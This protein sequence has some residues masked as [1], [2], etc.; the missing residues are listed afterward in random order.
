MQHDLSRWFAT[1]M[2]H[3]GD[4]DPVLRGIHM[5]RGA[6][7]G[8]KQ[9]VTAQFTDN[10]ADYHQRYGNTA[11]FRV[12][13]D[14]ALARLDPP[15]HPH[16]IL[17]IG[18]GSGNSVFPLLDRYPDATIVATDVS[19][20]LLAILRD[21]LAS[22]PA[23]VDRVALVCVDAGDAAYR[24]GAFDLAVG[25]AILHH[26]KDPT[27]VLQSCR[28][29]LRPGGV[30]IFFEPFE[31]GHAVLRLAYAGII[32]EAQRQNDDGPGLRMLRRLHD[33]Y[34][35]RRRE[36]DDPC[37]L[38][39]DDK[40]VFTRAF[41][42]AEARRGNWAEC[43]VHPIH[44]S[45]APL[46]EETRVN[47]R[48]GMDLGP[49]SLPRWA[50]ERLSEYEQAFSPAA[51]AELVFEGA[52]VLRARPGATFVHPPRAAWWFD[53]AA[54][55]QGFFVQH[56]PQA[57]L[58]V[59]CVYDTRGN[60]VWHRAGPAPVGTDGSLEAAMHLLALP[61]SSHDIGAAGTTFARVAGHA[62]AEGGGTTSFAL[63]FD[64]PLAA[65]DPRARAFDSQAVAPNAPGFA[66]EPAAF[67]S[68]LSASASAHP[69]HAWV[70][71]NGA[72]TRLTLQH[73]DS[74]GWSGARDAS[75]G[76]AWVEDR[77]DPSCAALVE[78]LG[79][80]VF[81]ALLSATEWIVTVG[82]RRRPDLYAGEWL[83]FRGG[84]VPGG[85][86]QAPSAPQVLGEARLWWTDTDRM[87]L[88]SP[89]GEHRVLRRLAI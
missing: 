41:F 5:P 14:D 19:P 17:D 58:V 12:L 46:T 80:R 70:E 88:Q 53:A 59:A 68:D 7:V 8:T 1:P 6:T 67:A 84:Q 83:R 3:L 52:V 72:R 47:L 25:A 57:S 20:P 24:P 65:S 37:L 30:A 44:A 42:E 71:W 45:E 38:D 77:D 16:T 82:S 35:A 9:G 78:Y 18:S 26:V 43:H 31:M 69:T 87:V 32:A 34:V 64:A 27:D 21:A 66:A 86:Y 33:D 23:D 61:P 51:R 54:P 13:L 22:R 76:G 55:G 50:W 10:A 49:E 79:E 62:C 36:R 15:L 11:H 73:A 40:W 48:L 74:P 28:G 56:A 60:P 75:A 39:L 81:V 85:P 63:T 29:A 4:A 2:E 89:G